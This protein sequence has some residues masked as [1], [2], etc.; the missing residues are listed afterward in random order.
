MTRRS[1]WIAGTIVL[2]LI[3]AGITS[4]AQGMGSKRPTSGPGSCTLI[5]WNPQTD[6]KNAKNLPVGHRPQTYKPDNFNCSSAKFAP[7]GA[8]FKKFPQPHD[9]TTNNKVTYDPS[10]KGKPATPVQQPVAAVNPLAPYFPPFK[11]FVIMYREN[12]TFDDYLGDCATTIAGRL[13]RTGGEHQ[14]H[15]LG[16]GPAQPGQ[17]LRAERL[18]QHRHPAA[19]GPQPLV[20]VL[21]A[22]AVQ[23]AAAVL[24]LHRDAV[25]PLPEQRQRPD[26]RGHQRVRRPDRRRVA[27]AARTRSS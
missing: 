10:G 1:Y 14:P 6:P 13:Q 7:L 9:F 27:A 24:P 20:A 26:G 8:E 22:V 19:V 12:H 5:G 4:A 16:T 25:R 23:L 15:Q 17:D 2:A 21:G 11:H 18:L 3:L